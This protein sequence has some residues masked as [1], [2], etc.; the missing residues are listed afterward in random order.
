MSDWLLGAQADSEFERERCNRL[1]E[2]Q[3]ESRKQA[4]ELLMRNGQYQAMI[5]DL[6]A[7]LCS[8]PSKGPS[9]LLMPA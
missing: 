4:E 9:R 5:T 7:P 1:L 2:Q 8:L 3:S 6:Q